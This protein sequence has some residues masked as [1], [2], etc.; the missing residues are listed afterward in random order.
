[1]NR[2][3]SRTLQEVD[4]DREAAALLGQ[5]HQSPPTGFALRATLLYQQRAA[6][7]HFRRIIYL[8]TA[9]LVTA[10]A[11]LWILIF[12]F[13]NIT[14]SAWYGVKT[15]ASLISSVM[16]FWE[17]VPVVCGVVTCIMIGLS[18]L[19][20]GMLTKLTGHIWVK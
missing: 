20:F 2:L 4:I 12:N 13:S 1:M 5:T 9:V 3:H 6:A 8:F 18:A 15:V 19:N 14:H 16:V 11:A 10:S 17:S 7:R